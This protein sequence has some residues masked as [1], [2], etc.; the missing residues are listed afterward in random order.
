MDAEMILGTKHAVQIAD[1]ERRIGIVEE[2]SR[3]IPSVE[4]TLARLDERILDNERRINIIDAAMLEGKFVTVTDHEKLVTD[5]RSLRESRSG[6]QGERGIIERYG[7]WIAGIVA[8]FIAAHL[9][10]K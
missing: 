1:L 2:D 10:W 9:L 8:A 5:V 7:G 3:R 6:S 4:T